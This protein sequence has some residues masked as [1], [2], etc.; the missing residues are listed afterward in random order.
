M[1]N[2]FFIILLLTQ[3]AQALDSQLS[4]SGAQT[5]SF[6]AAIDEEDPMQILI[7]NM[8]T[9]ESEKIRF[10]NSISDIK[11]ISLT[12]SDDKKNQISLEMLLVVVSVANA[13]QNINLY[14][15]IEPKLINIKSKELKPVCSLE[16]EGDFSWESNKDLQERV[17]LVTDQKNTTLQIKIG[18]YKEG[19][20]VFKWAPCFSYN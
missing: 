4:F 13:K 12:V 15:P 8:Q 6:T 19:K 3:Y 11:K 14:I 7:K 9:D 5:E 17:R 16:N 18:H 2:L 10:K 20:V 1:K